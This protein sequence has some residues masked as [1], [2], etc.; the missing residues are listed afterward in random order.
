MASSLQALC[1]REVLRARV[2]LHTLA[3]M[4]ICLYAEAK[5]SGGV[6]CSPSSVLRLPVSQ[7]RAVSSVWTIFLIVEAVLGGACGSLCLQHSTGKGALVR[8]HRSR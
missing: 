1:P 6:S 4:G 3:F 5:G 2:R 7:C 8:T